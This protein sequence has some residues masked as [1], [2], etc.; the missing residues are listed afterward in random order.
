MVLPSGW[1]HSLASSNDLAPDEYETLADNVPRR[2][3]NHASPMQEH[4]ARE[5]VF[6][7]VVSEVLLLPMQ[8]LN[9]REH[10]VGYRPDLDTGTTKHSTMTPSICRTNGLIIN[11]NHLFSSLASLLLKSSIKITMGWHSNKP[12]YYFYVKLRGGKLKFRGSCC[13]LFPVTPIMS[14]MMTL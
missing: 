8:L 12:N 3:P 4:H 14:R 7:D 11:S 2:Y 13:F 6:S 10:E 5:H 9:F 1:L